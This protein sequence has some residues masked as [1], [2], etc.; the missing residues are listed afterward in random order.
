MKKILLFFMLVMNLLAAGI[1][2]LGTD[3]QGEEIPM[4]VEKI[5][6]N[7]TIRVTIPDGVESLTT[8]YVETQ[9]PY[10]VKM[11]YDDDPITIIVYN[12]HKAHTTVL[13][14]SITNY[15][16]NNDLVIEIKDSII[17]PF[18]MDTKHYKNM[19]MDFMIQNK[20]VFSIYNQEGEI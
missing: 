19:R 20:T 5:G 2:I 12:K 17:Y 14:D 7:N 1:H 6:K 15:I 11:W 3:P 10:F 18:I 13:N 4:K 8:E 16:I 9:N